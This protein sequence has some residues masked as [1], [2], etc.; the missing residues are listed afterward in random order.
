MHFLFNGSPKDV[1]EIHV[2]EEMKEIGMEK[3]ACD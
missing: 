1:E 3:L 2:D